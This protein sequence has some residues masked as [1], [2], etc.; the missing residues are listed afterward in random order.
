MAKTGKGGIDVRGESADV[1]GMSDHRG[2]T[3]SENGQDSKQGDQLQNFMMDQ[4]HSVTAQDVKNAWPVLAGLVGELVD[5]KL[6]PILDR[7]ENQEKAIEKLRRKLVTIEC[8]SGFDHLSAD[9][10]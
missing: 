2:S 9:P 5:Q 8:R 4:V 6:S 7:L 10:I 3:G 1:S